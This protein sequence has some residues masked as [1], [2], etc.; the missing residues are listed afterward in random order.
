MEAMKGE[1]DNL[2]RFLQEVVLAEAT[3]SK[4]H[5]QEM[6][7]SALAQF[8]IHCPVY[9]WY[10]HAFP[11]TDA[12]VESIRKTL[13]LAAA[14]RPDLRKEL[15]LLEGLLVSAKKINTGPQLAHIIL[16]YQRCM[17]LTGA[18]M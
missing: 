11:L 18:L 10:G 12:E 16:F 3:L 17:Q 1:L 5:S 14:D 8:I 15:A 7:K 2:S 13:E 6:L 4:N 9:R